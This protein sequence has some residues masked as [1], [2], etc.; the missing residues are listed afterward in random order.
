MDFS[1]SKDQQNAS[2]FFLEHLKIKRNAFLN[3][4][5]GSG[6]TEIMYESILH[7]LNEGMKVIIT[8]PRKEIV[9]ELSLRL[10]NVFKD[11]TI[12]YLDQDN[13]LL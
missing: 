13:H 9:R 7:A 6:K 3:A 8:I 4:V 2:N 10:K 1:L 12:H 5:C 11:T